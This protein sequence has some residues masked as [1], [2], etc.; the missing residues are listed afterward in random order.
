MQVVSLQSPP[1]NSIRRYTHFQLGRGK[2]GI[3]CAYVR[4]RCGTGRRWTSLAN[5]RNSKT[6]TNEMK[7]LSKRKLTTL[8]IQRLG[9]RAWE[10]RDS[11]RLV[12]T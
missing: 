1:P 3:L 6:I 5:R 11:Y 8:L 2:P 4:M 12:E 10:N 7:K 9:D